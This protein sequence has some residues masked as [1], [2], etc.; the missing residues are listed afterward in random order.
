[1]RKLSEIE[2]AKIKLLT[3][4]RISLTL[5]EP[6]QTGLNKSI[7]DATGAVRSF[8]KREGAHNYEQ[9]KQSGIKN[10]NLNDLNLSPIHEFSIANYN[11]KQNLTQKCI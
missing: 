9:Q 11:F 7:M 3:K 8:L 1:M 5:I 4:N 6:T 2:Q 10:I